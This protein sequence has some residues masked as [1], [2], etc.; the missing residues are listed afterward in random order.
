MK[1]QQP[2]RL[3]PPGPTQVVTE[4]DRFPFRLSP[5]VLGLRESSCEEI[6]R[7]SWEIWQRQLNAL[8]RRF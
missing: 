1:E 2:Q 5:E 8:L 3:L 7:V 6:S 4:A